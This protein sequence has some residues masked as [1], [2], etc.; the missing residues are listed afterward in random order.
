MTAAVHTAGASQ[1]PGAVPLLIGLAVI[2]LLIA[3]R[4]RGTRLTAH[5]LFVL[6]VIVTVF[7]LAVLLPGLNPGHLRTVDY[8][9]LTLDVLLS[10]LLG[11]ARGASVLIY[12]YD[13]TTWFRYPSLTV[14]LWV[15]SLVARVAL[16]VAGRHEGATPVVTTDAVLFMLGLSLLTQNVVVWVR[17]GQ[18][19]HTGNSP[20]EKPAGP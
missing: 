14:A 3:R 7:G 5:R 4:T 9:V 10:L 18:V 12:P 11:V 6:P 15:V 1:G 17:R 20:A 8:A 2:V 16:G 13:G 19:R